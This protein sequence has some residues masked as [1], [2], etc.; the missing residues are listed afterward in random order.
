[1]TRA[2]KYQAL[3][4]A[5]LDPSCVISSDDLYETPPPP[6]RYAFVAY[7]IAGEWSGIAS[8]DNLED[9]ITNLASVY[10]FDN[11]K[12][13][14]LD[15]DEVVYTAAAMTTEEKNRQEREARQNGQ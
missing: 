8:G 11:V 9:L 10:W 2:E 5:D 12:I 15:T 7:T 6:G 4:P 3:L 14:D 1:M 13:I